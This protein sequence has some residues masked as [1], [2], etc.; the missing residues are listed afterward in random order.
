M[1]D[2]RLLHVKHS[3]CRKAAARNPAQPVHYQCCAILRSHDLQDKNGPTLNR[4]VGLSCI[5]F[6]NGILHH[7]EFIIHPSGG[8]W[9]SM[10]GWAS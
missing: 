3:T 1:H 5:L 2:G 7:Q 10:S 9:I 6:R 8:F 4:Q